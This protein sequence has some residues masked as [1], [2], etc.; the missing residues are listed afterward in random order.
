VQAAGQHV[1]RVQS[2]HGE[3]DAEEHPGVA[4]GTLLGFAEGADSFMGMWPCQ[5]N[6]TPRIIH[7]EIRMSENHRVS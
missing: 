5:M 4:P 2:G 3:T 1:E 7:Q 6:I